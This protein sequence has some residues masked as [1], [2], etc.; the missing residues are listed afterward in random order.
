MIVETLRTLYDTRRDDVEAWLIQKRREA[1]PF[2]TTSVDLRHAGMRL[3]PVDTNIYPAGFQNLSANAEARAAVQF[4]ERLQGAKRVLI[5]PENHTRNLPYF[6][7]LA[8]L[9]RILRRAGFDVEIGSL[10]AEKPLPFTTASGENLVQQPIERHQ[11]S[12]RTAH[13]FVPDVILLNNDCSSGAP[14]LLEHIAQ[15]ILPP[16]SMGWY[17]RLKSR[18]FTAYCA[19]AGEFAEAFGLDK[20]TICA[21][22]KA[23]TNVNFKTREGVDALA[24]EVDA[25][26][27]RARLK[28]TEYGIA[29]EPY[30]YVKADSGTYGMGIMVVKSGVDLLEM[31][32]KERN[33]MHVI[34][35]GVEVS[36]VILQEGIPTVDAVDG[37]P[38]EPMMYLVDGV[39][40]GGM[41][42]INANR[43]AYGNL[44]AAGMEFKGM[45]DEV[46]PTS[47][48]RAKVMD[49]DFRVYGLIATLAALAAARE[50]YIPN[51]SVM[52]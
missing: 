9:V 6:E 39:P 2:I 34:K 22:F 8:V 35:E 51:L 41:Y 21:D 49:C 50:N 24:Q 5:V 7:N 19:L 42:R 28:H 48:C 11:D 12:L 26:I 14:T 15:P 23:V 3:A 33:K 1:A 10:I 17:Q 52:A 29:D 43:D 20:W 30:V 32:K 36:N 37:K 25:M 27:A 38:A 4:K 46:E 13:G 31:N 18:H 44:N 45:C 16:V 47:D 40:V